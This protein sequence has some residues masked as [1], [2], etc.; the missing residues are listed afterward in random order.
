MRKSSLVISPVI[1]LA[2][3]YGL[4]K[5][6][7][8]KIGLDE[9]QGIGLYVFKLSETVEK[10]DDVIDRG[11]A[12]MGIKETRGVRNNNPGNIE[13]GDNWRGL[14]A[15][16]TDSRFAQFDSPVFG[17]RAIM[18]LLRN[19][20][21]RHN[22]NTIDGVIDRYAPAGDD[23][24]HHENYVNFVAS[25]V[26]VGRGDVINLVDDAPT[27]IKVVSA[28]VRFENGYQPY[29]WTVYNNAYME[30]LR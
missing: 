7:A 23:N 14:S 16:Q 3:L 29:P 19:Y 9:T 20:Q 21:T 22:I 26:G 6:G 2:G 4:G 15:V 8:R 18:V 1:I 25:E 28:I 24:P 12:K 13:K 27:I 11:L 5:I 17:I 30:Y 10:V